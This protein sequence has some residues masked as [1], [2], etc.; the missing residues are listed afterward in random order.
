MK[1]LSKSTWLL[2]GLLIAL[3]A[4]GTTLILT[5]PEEYIGFFKVHRWSE[6]HR[7][8]LPD[9]EVLEYSEIDAGTLGYVHNLHSKGRGNF[10]HFILIGLV[11]FFIIHAVNRKK[12]FYMIHGCRDNVSIENYG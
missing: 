9:N 1:K 8:G 10:F 2:I 3:T 12:K 6:F 5:M 11:V 7:V 4:L